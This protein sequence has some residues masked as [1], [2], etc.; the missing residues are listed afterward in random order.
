MTSA[1]HFS[2]DS[3]PGSSDGPTKGV[4]V[5]RNRMLKTY[6]VMGMLLA[7][8]AT[9]TTMLRAEVPE[10]T[11]S[12]ALVIRG[13]VVRA[14][15][16]WTGD[17]R[18]IVTEVEV[19][20]VETW[21]GTSSTTTVRIVQPGGQVGDIGQRVSG[22]ASFSMGEDVV[23]FLQHTGP[24]QYRVAGLAQGKYHVTADAQGR[25]TA[26]PE[27]LADAEVIDPSTRAPTLVQSTPVTLAAL[28]ARVRAVL[29][30]T[31]A[32]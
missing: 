2:Y 10:L 3:R 15:S 30:S 8:S 31:D 28:R 13:T 20:V 1:M 7:T 17:H 23:V 12:A 11:R 25:L 22:L 26:T 16:R 4:G 6:G 24:V 14:E 29:P 32:K 19:Q 5:M 21:K 18:R 9:G 27:K